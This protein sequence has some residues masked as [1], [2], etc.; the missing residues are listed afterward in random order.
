MRK[1]DRNRRRSSLADSESGSDESDRDALMN[2]IGV[3]KE[4]AKE[5]PEAQESSQDKTAKTNWIQVPSRA[6]PIRLTHSQFRNIMLETWINANGA[7]GRFCQGLNK[8]LKRL[9]LETILFHSPWNDVRCKEVY[10]NDE[11]TVRR[12]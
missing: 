1:R 7:A 4:I 8:K 11:T 12:L 3:N 10:P 9:G 5:T 2:S 6:Q